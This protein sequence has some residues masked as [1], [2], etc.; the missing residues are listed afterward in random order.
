VNG[1]IRGRLLIAGIVLGAFGDAVSA[2]EEP[3]ASSRGCAEC[4][5]LVDIPAGAFMMGS[6]GTETVDQGADAARVSNERPQHAVTIAA[7]FRLAP[8]EVTRAEFARFVTATGRD[9]AGCGNWENGGWV[10]HPEF[11]WR[12]PGFAQTDDDPVVCVSWVDASDYIG[13]LNARTGRTYRLPTEAEW[14]YAAR[15][16]HEGLH[17]WDDDRQACR[18]ANGADQAAARAQQLPQREGIIFDCDDG[19]AHTSPV[20]RFA[21][22]AFGLHDMLGNAWEWVADCYAPG[23]E[24]T[25]VDGS[26]LS[27]G[28]CGQ[29]VLRGGSWKYPARTVRFAI[30]GPGRVATRTNNAG[31]RLAADGSA[32]AGA[33]QRSGD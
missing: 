13:W 16:G 26:A 27:S 11:D 6:S 8:H 28:E 19:F 29:R 30:R 14:E 1:Q 21:A 31:F 4:P 17:N 3:P 22:N 15:A 9:M 10:V 20:G 33:A 5:L 2:G 24:G 23:Y 12:N 18:Y 32:P 7:G 25:P